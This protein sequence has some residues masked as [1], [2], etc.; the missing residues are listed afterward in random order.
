MINKKHLPLSSGNTSDLSTIL[1]LGPPISRQNLIMSS[2]QPTPWGHNSGICG[3]RHGGATAASAM[4]SAMHSKRCVSAHR[5]DARF[6]HRKCLQVRHAG[7]MR[8]YACLCVSMC[9]YVCLCV[10]MSV[11][12]CLCV[13]TC[14][15][16]CLCTSMCVYL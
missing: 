2:V 6:D 13:S 5:F 4:A 16:V 3:L 11:C 12:V 15:Y 9:V 1:A 7:L 8:V 14:V 10:S